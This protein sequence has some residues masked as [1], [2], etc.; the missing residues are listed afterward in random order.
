M[1]KTMGMVAA[2]AA[3]AVAGAMPV[4]QAKIEPVDGA[5]QIK[6]N[7]MIFGQFLEH[8]DNQVYG[9]VF[10]PKSRFADG[11]G[12]RKDVM[13]ALREIKCPIVRWPGGCFVS[14]YHWKDGVGKQREEVYDKAWHVYDPNTFGTDE[15]VKWCR[16][17]GCEPYICT[18]AGT[19]TPE[20]MSDWVEYCNQTGGKWAE[21]R[22]AN[23]NAEPLNVK[24]W[25]V[26]N[27]NYGPWEIGAKTVEEWGPLVR[28]SAKQMLAAD[29]SLNLLAAAT[30]NEGWTGPLLDNAGYLL[31]YVSIHGYW[32]PLH[33]VNNVTPYLGCMMRTMG[34][35]NSIVST[36]GILERHRL[37]GG[38][39]KIAF[40]EWNLR[41]W[42]HPYH[43]DFRAGFDLA[44]RRKNDIA[45]TYT[46]ADAVFSSC[47]LNAC[48]RHSDIVTMA[49]FAPCVNTRG[50][51]FAHKDGIVK[52]TTWHVFHMYTHLLEP[53]MTPVKLV[54]GD[55]VQGKAK[56]PVLD[57]ALTT[58][59]GGT[60]RVLAIANKHP[61]M[62]VKLDVSAFTAAK[63]LKGTVLSGSSPDDYNDIGAENRVTAQQTK[64]AVV[65]GS[66]AL[67]PHSVYCIEL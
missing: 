29:K 43:G 34:P 65:N 46:M 17:L 57:A 11:D 33:R 15:Y 59:D 9:G 4:E 63:A 38:R 55:L 48:L 13:E 16:K 21:L 20:E 40:D 2:L 1:K 61:S 51:I 50:C 39:V 45:A 56:V 32:D 62:S 30:A 14:S 26:G 60:R 24:Y 54:C 3:M 58:N 47:F 41:G 67:A 8:F 49:C 35:E 19:G 27:E 52:R 42:H 7:P 66:V 5:K 23:G 53:N 64:L 6:Y 25:S 31:N 36:I 18:N 37:G 10:D 28:E 22:K 44:A 12:F